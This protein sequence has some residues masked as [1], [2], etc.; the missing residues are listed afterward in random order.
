M[1]AFLSNKASAAHLALVAV[2][3]LVLCKYF[4]ETA[5]WPVLLWLSALVAIWAFMAPARKEE[6]NS[7]VA[8][9]RFLC[10]LV[11][12]PFTWVALVL[13]AYAAVAALNSGV[14]LAYDAEALT[15]RLSGPAMPELPGGVKGSGALYFSSALA[16]LAAYPAVVHSLDSRQAVS[17]GLFAT[18]I[19]LID[20]VFAYVSGTGIPAGSAA[21]YG[22][23]AMVAAGVMFSAEKSCSRFKEMLASLAL[24]GCIAAMLFAGNPVVI[25]VSLAAIL[26]VALVFIGFSCVDLRAIGITRA[27]LMLLVSCAAAAVLF[28]WRS[29]DWESLVPVFG[30]PEGDPLTRLAVEAWE[31]RP[32]VGIGAGA[33]PLAAK[34]GATPSDWTVLGA[35]PDFYANGWR[36]FLVERGMIG[37][38][39]FAVALGALA[40]SWFRGVRRRGFLN[41]TVAAALFPFAVAVVAVSLVYGSSALQADALVA[42]AALAALSV[43]GGV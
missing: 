2:A 27:L 9:N 1:L 36:A 23:W 24:T 28:H 43:N 22:L 32:W 38:V 21:A 34:I 10:G 41:F 7:M 26:A 8:R 25:C 29:G 20:A 11:S 35:V 3:P 14:A 5:V 37:V 39:A 40:F 42:F 30:I 19:V 18:L 12:D 31:T 6:E 33:F 16:V 13:L 4:G 17:F 15:W